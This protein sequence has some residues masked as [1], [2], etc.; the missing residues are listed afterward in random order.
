M[1]KKKVEVVSGLTK[2]IEGLFAKNKVEYIKGL[3]SFVDANTIKCDLNAGGSRTINAKNVIIATGS[4]PSPF[5]GIPFDEEV[6]VSSTGALGL[7]KIPKRMI[8][9]GAGYIGLEMGSVYQ[10]LGTEVIVIEYLERVVPALDHEIAN[11]F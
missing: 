2:G 11:H 1:M 4:E 8:V 10:R 9:I 7:K 3:G 5:P 6:F